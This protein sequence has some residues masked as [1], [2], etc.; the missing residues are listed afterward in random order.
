MTTAPTIS[1]VLADAKAAGYTVTKAPN[2]VNNQTAYKV[3]GKPGLFTKTG[4][5]QLVGTYA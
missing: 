5:M 2:K 3:A 4:L 1:T